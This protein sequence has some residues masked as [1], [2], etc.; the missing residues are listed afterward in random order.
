MTTITETIAAIRSAMKC[1]T[2]GEWVHQKNR[3]IQSK[4]DLCAAVADD[5]GAFDVIFYVQYIN[6]P[7]ANEDVELAC[8]LHNTAISLCD[9]VERLTAENARL[10]AQLEKQ[11]EKD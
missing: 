3:Y 2:Q 10:R 1:G 6:N 5:T 7:F 9:E 4:K 8:L 11:N